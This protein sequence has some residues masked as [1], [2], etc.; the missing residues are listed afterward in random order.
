MPDPPEQASSPASR[1]AESPWFWAM[2]FGLMA[3]FA[4]LVVGPKFAHRQ[5]QLEQ[6]YQGRRDAWEQRVRQ[7]SNP[8]PL[9]P[10]D[11]ASGTP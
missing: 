10:A 1:L 6:N 3:L 9:A 5:A 2:L 8:P 4:L 7:Q 11:T